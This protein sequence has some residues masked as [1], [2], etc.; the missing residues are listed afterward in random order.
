MVDA[1]TNQVLLGTDKTAAQFTNP[2]GSNVALPDDVG[3]YISGSVFSKNSASGDK[4]K[5]VLMVGGDLVV[6]GNTYIALREAPGNGSDGLSDF[7][8]DGNVFVSG[9]IHSSGSAV[10]G[11][12][13]FGGD[14]LVSGGLGV[15]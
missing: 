8:I 12:S 1:G 13:V 3:V 15:K 9:S 6:S 4:A 2:G 10:A 11:T 7:G 5:G 14:T